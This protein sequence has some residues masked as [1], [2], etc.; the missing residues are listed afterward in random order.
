MT[1]ALLIA[2]L[3]VAALAYVTAPLRRKDLI[4]VDDPAVELEEKKVVALTAIL[5]LENER[6][7]GK[8]SDEDFDELKGIYEAQA[9]EV[10]HELDDAT[11]SDGLDPIER[12]IALVRERMSGS[13]CPACGAPR[14][15]GKD[16]CAACGA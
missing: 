9:L 16:T 12:E 13:R 10:L 6:D 7:V 11:G 4:H 15:P 8:L 14:R 1:H 3:A 5:D 2:L